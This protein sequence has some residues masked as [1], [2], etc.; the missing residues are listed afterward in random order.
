MEIL[1]VCIVKTNPMSYR[2]MMA[3]RYSK[4][5]DS[6]KTSHPGHATTTSSG[7]ANGEQRE[8]YNPNHL[9]YKKVSVLTLRSIPPNDT[10]HEF[11]TRCISYG[12]C[13]VVS[14]PAEL[15]M[16]GWSCMACHD[17]GSNVT[18]NQT[19]TTKQA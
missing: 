5:T 19:A 9:V 4:R 15:V 17:T 7:S 13:H 11:L 14:A 6:N 3:H 1:E 12:T 10:C 16:F 8:E 18:T 2:S